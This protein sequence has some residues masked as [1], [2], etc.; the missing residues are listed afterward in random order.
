MNM[1]KT[2][3]RFALAAVAGL[4][5]SNAAAQQVTV[6]QTPGYS[7]N[8]GEFT[9]SPIVGAGYGADA[10][11]GGG[12]QSFCISRN[13]G[14]TLPGTYFY[15]LNPAGVIVPENKT[16]AKGTAW[17]YSHFAAGTLPNYR[18]AGPAIINPGQ[19]D[20]QRAS[21]AI[22]L[23]LALWTLQGQY[24]YGVGDPDPLSNYSLTQDLLNPWVNQVANA[25]GGGVGGLV[26]AMTA[27]NAGDYNVG[28]LN[29]NFIDLPL[30]TIGRVAQPVLVLLPTRPA[31]LGNY[32][33]ED[34]N[35]NGV[36]DATEH[37]I[38][39]ATV[40]LTDCSANPVQDASG[41]LVL[42]YLTAANGFYT[43][44]N[45]IPGDYK[46]TVTLP[47]GYVFTQ[48]FQG[49]DTSKDSNVNPANGVSDCRH[50]VAGQYDDTVDAG[51]HKPAP[52][53]IGNYIWEDKN[54]NGVQDATEPGIAGAVVSLSDC[55]GN[56]V[57]D[58]DG[59]PV[60]PIVTGTNGFYQFVNLAPG[61]YKVTVTLPSG[62]V[63][64]QSFQGSNVTKDS[65]VNP[66]SGMS[67]CRILVAGQYDDTVD[68]GAYKP[69][70]CT[71]NICGTI[72]ADCDG[73]G[74][75]SVKDVGLKNV[76]VKLLNAAGQQVSTANTDTNGSYCFGGLA[77]GSYKVVV[78]PPAGYKQTSASSGH[79]W[80][81]SYGRRCWVDND[82]NAHCIDNGTEC[83]RGKDN[84]VHW[85]DSY[86]RD[87]WKDNNN[88]YRCQ[89]ISYKTC[90]ATNID[91]T[92]CVTVT[93]CQ[94]KIDVNFA[95][96]GTTPN[97]VVCV[98][99]PS[100]AKCGQTVT[101]TCSAT[102]TGNVCFKGGTICHTIGNC[103]SYGWSGT[104]CTYTSS[105][106]PLSPGEHCEIKQTC[107][108]NS[109]NGGRNVS[110]Q[111]KVTC[112]QAYGTSA[113]GQSSCNTQCNW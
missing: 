112:T 38:A 76:L 24:S 35:T 100:S 93:N 22:T 51:A 26:I 40:V 94:S 96:T 39:G 87:C 9:V 68:A 4:L 70:V 41:S 8:D 12:F 78:T 11:V 2:L 29:L 97:L 30:G 81:D 90:N 14:I 17:L 98:S 36:Q 103:G 58:R 99:G 34:S 95:Y 60:F 75:L 105:C 71:A 55:G 20:S 107:T 79:Y 25:F 10:L 27:N 84:Y 82:D 62:F 80:K 104:P 67:D 21:D 6:S 63:F 56:S 113:S 85:K 91:N 16:I 52:A 7:G 43:F 108:L 83:W 66:A 5:V 53:A 48:S 33:W 88:N 18:Y 23:Q 49:G 106:P 13:A 57:S 45:L 37:G 109:W 65:N 42:P 15:S 47:G 46:V 92:L 77:A 50:L 32:V 72:F 54:I 3:G 74:D 86:G 19:T 59:N 1:Q 102:N 61:Q 73:S 28:V 89:P 69:A 101:Y 111:T 64:T 31:S 44:T 110:C